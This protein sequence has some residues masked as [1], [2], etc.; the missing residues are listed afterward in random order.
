MGMAFTV[1]ETGEQANTS[2]EAGPTEMLTLTT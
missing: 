1:T 2:F